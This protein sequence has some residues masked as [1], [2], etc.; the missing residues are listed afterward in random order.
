MIAHRGFDFEPPF[1]CGDLDLARRAKKAVTQNSGR[2]QV[3]TGPWVGDFDALGSHQQPQ[4]SSRGVAM[5]WRS[6]TAD[7]CVD[8][9]RVDDTRVEE[10]GATD[11]A[12]DESVGGPVVDL[13]RRAYL[14]EPS[15]A[16]QNDAIRQR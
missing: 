15:L 16:Q 8:T 12:R 1:A 11:K 9:F 3:F 5:T 14:G 2:K 10:V 7:R 4:R 6:E 13:L